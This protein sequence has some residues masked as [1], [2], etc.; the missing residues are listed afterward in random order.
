[1]RPV[2]QR[3]PAPRDATDQGFAQVVLEGLG[4]GIAGG[5]GR[6]AAVPHD[7]CCHALVGLAFAAGIIQ[8]RHVGVGMHVDEA[9]RDYV[10]GRV[11]APG[12]HG[13]AL[14]ADGRIVSI[15][16]PEVGLVSSGVRAVD[17]SAVQDEG[18]E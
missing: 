13:V 1:M 4:S 14:G 7:L 12:R 10:A 6:V 8:Q 5:E 15:G 17:Y 9:R 3:A 16:Q 2:V 11:D 18:V